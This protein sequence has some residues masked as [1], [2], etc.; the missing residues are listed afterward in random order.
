MS[1]PRS[2]IFAVLARIYEGSQAGRTGVG[3][4]AVQPAFALVC[5]E[6]E[7]ATGRVLEGEA[8]ELAMEE[9]HAADGKVLRLEWENKRARTTLRKIRLSP[10]KEREFYEWI[11]RESPTARRECWGALFRHA[12]DWPVPACLAAEWQSF[13]VA[14]A[15]RA[16]HWEA[17]E[18][19]RQHD[20]AEGSDLLECTRDL[21][22]WDSPSGGSLIRWVSS[23]L[24]GRSKL[25]E[26]ARAARETLLCEAS[27]GRI[28]SFERHGILAMPREAR[29]SGPLRL[30]IDGRTLD[31]AAQEVTTLS[32]AD[33]QRAEF[34]DC[35]AARCLTV[36]NKTVFLD[37][38]RKRSGEMIVWTSF[39]N[40]AT[41]ALLSL[42]P[43]TLEFRHFGDTD[44]SGFH[45]LHV[46][47]RKTQLPFRPFRMQTRPRA[48]ARQLTDPERKL[49]NK[50]LDSPHLIASRDE[51][52]SIL[53][54]DTVGAFEQEDH[55]P[56]PLQD[57][58]F[59]H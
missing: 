30:R 27:G 22:A 24:F 29:V 46:L 5:A 44:P 19:F 9:L 49:L 40:A 35:K 10:A 13:C 45:I 32:L 33:L 16:M 26:T 47:C 21:L 53:A 28:A 8:Y 42:L 25:L 20:L 38:A 51:L 31:C 54:S 52:R 55:Q 50:L 43:R 6:F 34:I 39:P 48:S 3:M 57:W 37:L 2:P 56:A 4:N 14:R 59:F 17:M 36:E 15:A 23:H 18:P 41:R 7:K 1:A 58:P 12:A 11:G